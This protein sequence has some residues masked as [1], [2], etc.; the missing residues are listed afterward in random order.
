MNARFVGSFPGALPELGLPEI[1]FAGRSN[2]GKSSALNTLVN[3]RAMARVSG[4]PGRTQAINLFVVDE[5]VAFADLPGY[6]FA[7][8]PD[9]VREAWKPMIERYLTERARLA[10]V[11]VLIDVRRDVQEMDGQMLY[12]LTEARIPSLVVATKADK[13]SKQALQRQLAALRAGYR[14]PPEQPI[15]FSS[16]DRRGRDAVWAEIDARCAPA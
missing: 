12:A 14:L 16:E 13:L 15:A 10:L 11:V 5:R 3:H 2:V 4:T 9:A 1:A 7:K 6:G 8:V